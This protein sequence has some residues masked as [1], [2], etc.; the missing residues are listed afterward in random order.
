MKNNIVTMLGASFILLT[1]FASCSKDDPELV[2]EQELI[3]A[4]ELKFTSANTAAQTVRWTLD[5]NSTPSIVLQSNTQYQV[6]VS[7]LD[8]S[9]PADV[10][11]ITEEVKEEAD[12]HQLF[13]EFSGV[14]LDFSSADSDVLDSNNNPLNV[15][16]VWNTNASG[17]GTVRLYLIHEPLTKNSSN[18][19]GFGGETDVEVDFTIVVQE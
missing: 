4:V 17:S 3:T 6:A 14:S 10:E 13:Y 11:D 5:L 1:I 7:F 18:R 2:E 9:D 19:S 15:N 16:S 12:E 8:E